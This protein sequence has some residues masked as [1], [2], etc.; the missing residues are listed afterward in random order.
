MRFGFVVPFASEQEFVELARL[1]EQHGWHGVFSWEGVWRQDAWVQLAAAAMVTERV[2]LGTVVTPVS[3]Y[4]PWDLASLVGSV[5]RLSDGRVTLGVGL[6][7]PN[8]NWTAFEADD[9]RKTRAGHVDEGLEL[10][11][12]LCSGEPF[13]HTGE[14]WTI[15]LTHGIEPN[16]PPPTAQQP[17]PPVW[18]VGAL[19]PG[20]ASQ[21]SLERAAHWEG[22]FPAIARSNDSALTT[23]TLRDIVERLRR[24]RESAGLPWDGYDVIVAG[25]S[26]GDF[27]A[28]QGGPEQ[29]EAAGA[30]WWME[31]WWDVPP[32]PEG[33]AE[34][35]RRVALGPPQQG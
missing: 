6:G 9:G 3:R 16:G 14:R 32:G 10:F 20:R 35:K 27:D 26:C 24:L 4:R 30:T 33:V 21:P 7:A 11:A 19:V 25:D 2:R 29:W 22:C 31:S 28:V 5:D 12:K 8:S 34:L 15:D 17:H 1:G 13:R 18:C 23:R